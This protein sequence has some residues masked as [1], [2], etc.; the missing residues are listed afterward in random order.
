M[1]ELEN[2]FDD[3]CNVLVFVKR[4]Q[5]SVEK[6]YDDIQS[7]IF[8]VNELLCEFFFVIFILSKSEGQEQVDVCLDVYQ[9]VL[10]GYNVE[11]K[12]FWMWNKI[13]SIKVSKIYVVKQMCFDLILDILCC[14]V[15]YLI[16]FLRWLYV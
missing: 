7:F 13:L 11:G 3:F 4:Y 1:E 10:D 12:F 15:L 14:E 5:Q 9:R 2:C 16:M 6:I 8:E